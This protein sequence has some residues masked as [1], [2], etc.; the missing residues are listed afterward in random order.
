[1]PF[2]WTLGWF[3]IGFATV[4]FATALLTALAYAAKTRTVRVPFI[5]A[6]AAGYW[7]ALTWA[8]LI[9]PWP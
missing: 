3:G 9:P 6:L 4:G 2:G 8:L 7:L 1:M 5:P